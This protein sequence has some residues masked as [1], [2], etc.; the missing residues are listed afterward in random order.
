MDTLKQLQEKGG[1]ELDKEFGYIYNYEVKDE[2]C[3]KDFDYEKLKIFINQ[4]TTLAF[5]A[6]K[7]EAIAMVLKEIEGMIVHRPEE[8]VELNKDLPNTI[9]EQSYLEAVGYCDALDTLKTKLQAKE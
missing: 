9:Q 2:Y 8:L 3:A 1:G 7:A 4:Q 5:E 6:G